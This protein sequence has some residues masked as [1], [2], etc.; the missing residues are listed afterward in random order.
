MKGANHPLECELAVI[1]CGLSGFSAA[2][3]AAERGISTVVVGVSGATMFA[4]GLLDLLGTHPVETGNKWQDPW[5]AMEVLFKDHPDHPY[6]RIGRET[7][8]GSLEK[9]VS[10]LRS[11][12]LSYLK[13]G[14]RNSEVMTPLGTSKYTYYVPQTM[15]HG[16]EAL[17]EKK[18]CL[19]VGFK[20]LTDFSATQIAETMADRWPGIRGTDVVFPGSEK[21]VG[22]VSGDI[23]A[24]DME[25]PGNLEKLVREIRPLLENAEAV[26]LPAVLGMNRSHEIVEELSA[27]LNRPVFE[28]PTMPLS[29][30]GLRLNEAFT[31]GLSARGVRFFV[32]NRVTHWEEDDAGFLLSVGNKDQKQSLRAEGVILATGRFWA[33]GLRADRDKIREPLFDLPVSQPGERENWHRKEFLDQRGHPANQA[34]IEVDNL[35]RPLNEKGDPALNNLFGCGSILAHQDWMRSKCGSGL[36]ISTAWAA[37]EAFASRA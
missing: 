30:P 7:I 9:V 1:G 5:E 24:R 23:M 13:V 2:L 3:F 4:S 19:I 35:F 32:P 8:A 20:G 26:G 21:V 17:Q 33:R 16:I 29:V 18:P 6:A 10:F 15:W 12:G 36:A 14:N 28:I 11:E 22:L 37:V 31:S 34:G 25:F 27:E